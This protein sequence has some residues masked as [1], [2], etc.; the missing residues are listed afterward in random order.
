M[1]PNHMQYHGK[2]IIVILYEL[3]LCWCFRLACTRDSRISILICGGLSVVLWWNLWWN[4]V[5]TLTWWF[6]VSR[7]KAKNTCATSDG[8][9]SGPSVPKTD[10]KDTHHREM[11]LCLCCTMI[12]LALTLKIQQSWNEMRVNG[13]SQCQDKHWHESQENFVGHFA[14]CWWVMKQSSLQLYIH[15]DIQLISEHDL[16]VGL[17]CTA[18]CFTTWDIVLENENNDV[19]KNYIAWY[20]TMIA[21]WKKIK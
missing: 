2:Q 1:A 3:V 5:A 21:I 13:A 7:K 15:K 12:E 10:K 17:A 8:A 19:K 18:F 14:R 16:F 6:G 20:E 9:I 4:N 11:T